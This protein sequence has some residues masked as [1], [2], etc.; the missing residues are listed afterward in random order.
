MV[1]DLQ[2]LVRYRVSF[3]EASILITSTNLQR[4]EAMVCCTYDITLLRQTR[5]FWPATRLT[6]R[7]ITGY[8]CILSMDLSVNDR[9]RMRVS[10]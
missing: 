5:L 2:L 7:P 1:H 4:G 8:K 10:L 3:V 9:E 6:T